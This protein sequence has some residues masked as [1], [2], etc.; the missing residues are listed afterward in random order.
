MS[1]S[2]PPAL[3]SVCKLPTKGRHDL[4]EKTDLGHFAKIGPSYLSWKKS[5]MPY[6]PPA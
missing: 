1:L 4:V 3:R 6:I 2:P 5:G